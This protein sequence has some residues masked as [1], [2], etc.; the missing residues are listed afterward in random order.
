MYRKSTGSFADCN[1]I[2]PMA[3]LP[4]FRIECSRNTVKIFGVS[5]TPKG[6]SWPCSGRLRSVIKALTENNRDL[7][8][9][10]MP[11]A[12]MNESDGSDVELEI[13]VSDGTENKNYSF[14]LDT[15][16]MKIFDNSGTEIEFVGARDNDKCFLF[17]GRGIRSCRV[18][19]SNWEVSESAGVFRCVSRQHVSEGK[20][21]ADDWE[22]A[23]VQSRNW[24]GDLYSSL[25]NSPVKDPEIRGELAAAISQFGMFPENTFYFDGNFAGWCRAA[26]KLKLPLI[27]RGQLEKICQKGLAWNQHA[28][29]FTGIDDGLWLPRRSDIHGDPLELDW[30]VAL[31]CSYSCIA[32]IEMFDYCN[33]LFDMS[34]LEKYAFSFMKGVMRTAELLIVPGEFKLRIPCGV[35]P[36]SRSDSLEGWGINPDRQLFYLHTLNRKLIKAAS[37]LGVAPDPVWLDIAQRLPAARGEWSLPVSAPWGKSGEKICS[38]LH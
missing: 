21:V 19:N 9:A 23:A 20:T 36:G 25:E 14:E 3:F 11:P 24:W 32:A 37:L 6:V 2:A 13:E 27:L 26:R 1:G 38:I 15:G 35:L 33:E 31:D 17:R 16:I 18:L 4:G 34:F 22:F 12:V 8:D 5:L 29:Y 7:M 28:K 30:T 10:A